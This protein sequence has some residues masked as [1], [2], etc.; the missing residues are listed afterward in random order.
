MCRTEVHSYGM[1]NMLF[2]S[3]GTFLHTT[4]PTGLNNRLN[5]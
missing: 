2:R 3:I 5:I 1:H 4:I